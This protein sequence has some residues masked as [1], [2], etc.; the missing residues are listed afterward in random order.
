MPNSENRLRGLYAIT[1]EKL[2]P[3]A[4]FHQVIEQTLQGGAGI[5][6]YRDKSGNLEKR[7]KQAAAL[8]LLCDQYKAL[9]LINDDLELAR[10]V[11][12][13]GIHLG[14]NDTPISEARKFLGEDAIIGASCYNQLELAIK[15]ENEGANYVAFGAFFTSTIKPEARSA[16]LNL[17]IEAKHRLSVPV[18]AIGGINLNNAKKVF[19]AGADMVAVISGLFAQP[20]VKTISRRITD[21]VP[22]QH[23]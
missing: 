4:Q 22:N 2:I 17:I 7:N 21:L 6:Q 8:R 11:N 1:D 23:T 3:E 9:L 20:Q 12:A 16:E 5:I 18:C 15:A 10:L 19:D 13:D 14:E